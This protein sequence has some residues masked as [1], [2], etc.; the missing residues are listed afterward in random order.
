MRAKKCIFTID[1]EDWFHILDVPSTPKIEKWDSLPSRVE[2]NFERL[3]D[4][5]SE[6]NV[7]ATCFVLGWIGRRFP[8][9]IREANRRGHEIAS[10]GYAHELVGH[11]TPAEFSRDIAV[12]KSILE[13]AIGRQV[14]G[15]RAPGFSTTA[16]TP[17]FFR[18]VVEA[19]Y[20]Y[21]SSVFPVRCGHGGL[22][23]APLGPYLIKTECGDLIEIPATV[24]SFLGKRLCV[25]GGGYLRL[26]PWPL[27]SYLAKRVLR[28][29]RPVVCYVHP[30]EI[31]LNHPRLE[32]NLARKFRSYVNLRTSERKIRRL[33]S[34]F[35]F[36]SFREFLTDSELSLPSA[37]APLEHITT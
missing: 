7:R 25:F 8:R 24:A 32:M 19:G 18:K 29:G 4:L 30:R 16:E 36:T 33:L 37:T 15:Y 11:M 35:K 10:H 6:A 1:V 22:T 14:S 20:S 17:W 28:E 23:T 5:F 31:D 9:L 21:D 2:R 26:A 13:D 34:T 27:I 12:A 3:L